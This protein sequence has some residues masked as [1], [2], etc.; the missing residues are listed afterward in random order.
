MTTENHYLIVSFIRRKTTY[1]LVVISSQNDYLSAGI[2]E[3]QCCVHTIILVL[4]F[5]TLAFMRN[6]DLQLNKYRV[7]VFSITQKQSV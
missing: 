6:G 3:C 2:L 5:A 7:L 1:L 4:Y